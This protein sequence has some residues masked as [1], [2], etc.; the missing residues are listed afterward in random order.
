MTEELEPLSDAVQ[1]ALTAERVHTVAPNAELV[2][3]LR[4]SLDAAAM[5]SA[6]A[7]PTAGAVAATA[8]GVPKAVLVAAMV[9]TTVIAASA[10]WYAREK[11][12]PPPRERIVEV[13]KIVRVEVPVPAAP[14]EVAAKPNRIERPAPAVETPAQ[15]S[16]QLSKENALLEMARSALIA[17]RPQ[18]ALS[19]LD[20]HGKAFAKPLLTEEREALRIRALLQAGRKDEA[21]AKFSQFET[22]WPH[23]IVSESLRSAL[24]PP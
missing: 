17:Q 19:A 9:G 24:S 23:S 16:A 6:V 10:G 3:R 7:A 12:L 14:T 18:D 5:A 11:T 2:G 1:A 8:V 22:Q 20:T 4:A 21:R 15:R 13:E